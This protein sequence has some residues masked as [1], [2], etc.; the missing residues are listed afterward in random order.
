MER[1]NCIAKAEF[2]QISPCEGVIEERTLRD[3][4][5]VP[6]CELHLS[7]YD[8]QETQTLPNNSSTPVTP[9]NSQ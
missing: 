7:L 5:T 9:Q 1:L 3:G 8:L 2:V 4:T 6:L